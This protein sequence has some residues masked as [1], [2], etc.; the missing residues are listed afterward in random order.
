MMKVQVNCAIAV[1]VSPMRSHWS[2]AGHG[3]GFLRCVIS[4][5]SD[6]T[7]GVPWSKQDQ[8]LTIAETLDGT[9]VAELDLGRH[10]TVPPETSVSDTVG[11]MAE[12]DLAC[13][14]IVDG[15]SLVGIFT[16][17]D[18]LLRAIGRP[19]TWN[20]PIETEMSRS[21]RT[22]SE[23]DTVA[24]GLE[25]MVDWW[26][27]N[28]PVLRRDGG[29]AGNLSFY[30]VMK[31][32]AEALTSRIDNQSEPHPEHGLSFVDFTGLNM[33]P[34]VIVDLEDPVSHTAHHMRAR[35][36]GSVLVADSRGHL[37]GIVTEFDLLTRVGCQHPDP[38]VLRVKQVMSEPVALSPRS[39]IADG[40]KEIAAQ[41]HSH[42]PLVAESGRPAGTAS[43]R[44]VAAYVEAI[45]DALD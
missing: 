30:T 12:A 25:I 18:V 27:R 14:L 40:I 41:G 4:R 42:V 6:T 19:S 22:M 45:L 37:A 21:V 34:P 36:I 24:D 20:R 38:S 13:A 43:F 28:V 16:Q 17:R 5:D 26:V 7:Q 10:V 32:I 15:D 23:T 2:R 29:L 35:G 8:H 44:D 3:H 1:A 39:S 9:S 11:T 33:S 31:L